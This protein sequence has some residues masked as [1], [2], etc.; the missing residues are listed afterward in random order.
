MV[1]APFWQP[2]DFIL[3][4]LRGIIV[5]AVLEISAHEEVVL[6]GA[7]ILLKIGKPA[8]AST[9]VSRIELVVCATVKQTS[10]QRSCSLLIR[11]IVEP[12]YTM[13]VWQPNENRFY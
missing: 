7:H 3:D 1:G 8:C 13:K 4:E 9:I 5:A 2:F 6:Q 10:V 12:R 11:L